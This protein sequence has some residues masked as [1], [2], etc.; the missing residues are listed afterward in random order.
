MKALITGASSGIGR[1]MARSLSRRGADLVLVARRVDRMEQLKEELDTDVQIIGADLSQSQAC[2]DLYEGLKDQ[3]IDIVIN[4]AGFG[5]FGAFDKTDLHR[6][7]EMIDTN[8]RAVHILTKLFLRDFVKQ[9]HGY[10]LNVASSAAFL[11]G[12]LLSTYYATKSYVLRLTEAVYEELRRKGSRVGISVLCPGPVQTEFNEVAHGQFSIKGLSSQR[13][14]EYAVRK[15]LQKDLVILPGGLMKAT[16]FA[17]R[18]FSE[19]MLLRMCYHM[20][21]RKIKP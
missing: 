2:F 14:A 21:K 15:M 5:L 13:V 7:L 18:F 11:P 10:L 12:P 16:R 3:G 4:N 19:K 9:D 20:Q 6:E 8:I 1:D 17:E